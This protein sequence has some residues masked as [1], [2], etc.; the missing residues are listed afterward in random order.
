VCDLR[1]EELSLS[2]AQE[3]GGHFSLLSGEHV[4]GSGGLFC[5]TSPD[6][7]SLVWSFNEKE[8]A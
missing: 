1:R 2:G 6:V 8:T 7:Q 4:G 3:G 5:S